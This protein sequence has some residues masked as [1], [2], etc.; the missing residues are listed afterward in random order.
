MCN[1]QKYWVIS[2]QSCNFWKLVPETCLV[3]SNESIAQTSDPR[4]SDA[5]RKSG[6]LWKTPPHEMELRTARAPGG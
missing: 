6:R 2:F 3:C 5:E 4:Y 1:I